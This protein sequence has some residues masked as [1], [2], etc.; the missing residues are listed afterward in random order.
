[1]DCSEDALIMQSIVAV[2]WIL[3]TLH[4]SFMCHMLY[5]YLITN[6]GNPTSLEYIVWSFPASI[7]VNSLVVITTQFFFAHKIYHL[8]RRRLL[9]WL[10]ILPIV[11]LILVY[12][13]FV[14]GT[15]VEILV[16]NTLDFASET[17]FYTS[18]PATLAVVLA[19]VLITISLCILLYDSGSH[20]P[21]PRTKRLLKALVV[22]AINRCLLTLIVTIAEVIVVVDS[23]C[24]VALTM[25]LEFI[26]GKRL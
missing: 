7:L 12:F 14:T 9:R 16:D 5:Y 3:D 19:E 21:F 6:F 13:G 2:I 11:L 18:T 20:S 23:N 10:A 1:M 22:Y 26:V 25:A 15:A 17:R 24:P 8:C 4:V